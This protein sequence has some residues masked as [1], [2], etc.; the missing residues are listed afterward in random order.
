MATNKTIPN[1]LP[2]GAEQ[3]E[4]VKGAHACRGGLLVSSHGC[5]DGEQPRRPWYEKISS[6]RAVACTDSL[7]Q[8]VGPAR[9]HATLPVTLRDFADTCLLSGG[10]ADID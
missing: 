1:P 6:L 4:A 10:K 8:G 5:P 3:L 2:P 9:P 7:K